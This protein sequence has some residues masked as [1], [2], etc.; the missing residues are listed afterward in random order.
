MIPGFSATPVVAP[1]FTLDPATYVPLDKCDMGSDLKVP[2]SEL[3]VEKVS[4]YR[5]M[6]EIGRGSFGTIYTAR[7][8]RSDKIVAI[9]VMR[10]DTTS[11]KEVETFNREV[12]VLAAVDHPCLLA[13]RG[14]VP[15]GQEC[16]DPAIITEYCPRGS[17]GGLIT[18]EKSGTSP[19]DWDETQ[20]FIVFYGIAVGMLVLHNRRIINRDMKPENILLTGE[21]E[22]RVADFGLSKFVATGATAAQTVRGGT[23]PY[24]APEIYVGMDYDFK[25]DVYAFGLI[26]YVTLTGCIPFP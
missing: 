20:R 1:A 15:V 25:V 13:F 17:L 19:K 21:L 22:P 3:V 6:D 8:R 2:L 16:D 23:V 24:M 7:A 12:E 10:I 9:K 26:V 11:Q 14:Y 5:K 4:T 18:D